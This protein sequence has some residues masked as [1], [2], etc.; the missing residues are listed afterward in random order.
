MEYI[1]NIEMFAQI[2]IPVAGIFP[3]IQN[4][5]YWA[6]IVHCI[7][8]STMNM[9]FKHHLNMILILSQAYLMFQMAGCEQR[10]QAHRADLGCQG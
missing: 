7:K 4:S 2:C 10:R 8:S 1:Q 3:Y 9:V 5:D 6:T